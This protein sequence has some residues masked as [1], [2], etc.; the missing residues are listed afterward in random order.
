MAQNID[1]HLQGKQTNWSDLMPT[2]DTGIGATVM[3]LTQINPG[4]DLSSLGLTGCFQY[5]TVDVIEAWTPVANIGQTAFAIPNDPTLSGFQF[6]TQGVA[7]SL[8]VNPADTLTSN[9]LSLTVGN[10]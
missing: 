1:D 7:F 10:F 4:T 2:S 8:G 9:G 5:V 6:M 3:S